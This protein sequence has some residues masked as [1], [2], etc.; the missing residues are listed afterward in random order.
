[1]AFASFVSFIVA[2]VLAAWHP[3]VLFTQGA[4]AFGRPA[5]I[6]SAIAFAALLCS[7][8]AGRGDRRAHSEVDD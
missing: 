6:A 5:Q 4:A 8:V 1:M 3:A 2:G 7:L